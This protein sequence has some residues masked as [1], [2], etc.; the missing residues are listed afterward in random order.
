VSFVVLKLAV[1]LV[2]LP[3]RVE[4][5]ELDR[6][7][8]ERDCTALLSNRQRIRPQ[9]ELVEQVVREGLE[10]L[11]V[12]VGIPGHDQVSLLD[13]LAF[14]ETGAVL[15]PDIGVDRVGNVVIAGHEDELLGGHGKGLGQPRQKLA[16]LVEA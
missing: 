5:D 8:P 9:H 16:G 2:D 15:T 10:P 13:P 1:E 14:A 3:A 12:L 11:G 7:L 6:G 4:G